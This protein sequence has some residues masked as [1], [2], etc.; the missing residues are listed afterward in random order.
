MEN[1]RKLLLRLILLRA[2]GPTTTP[3]RSLFVRLHAIYICL[4]DPMQIRILPRQQE[5]V[6]CGDSR[7]AGM[8]TER[9]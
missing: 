5:H 4:H 1:K 9:F 6:V 8:I 2:A 7:P 3:R